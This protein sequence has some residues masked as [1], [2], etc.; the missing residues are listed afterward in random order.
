MFE[1]NLPSAP[2]DGLSVSPAEDEPARPTIP[3]DGGAIQVFRSIAQH[4]ETPLAVMFAGHERW[5]T[6]PPKSIEWEDLCTLFARLDEVCANKCDVADLGSLALETDAAGLG[7]VRKMLRLVASPNLLYRV[8]FRWAGNRIFPHIVATYEELDD[9]RISGTLTIPDGCCDSPN[10]FKVMVGNFRALPQVLGLPSAIVDAEITERHMACLITPPPSLTLLARLARGIRAIFSVKSALEEMG[11]QQQQL[12]R[13]FGE[14]K[15][16]N[17]TAHEHRRRAE[18]E[19]ERAERALIVKSEFIATMSHEVRTPLNGITGGIE[20]LRDAVDPSESEMLEIVETSVARLTQMLEALLDFS[21]LSN[22][23]FKLREETF[24]VRRFFERTLSMFANASE[25]AGLELSCDVAN[26]VPATLV[27]DVTRVGQVLSALLD[28]ALKFTKQGSIAVTV[29]WS[30]TPNPTMWIRV[31]DTGPGIA[32]EHRARIFQ[33]FSQAD[34]SATREAGGTGL[35][36]A[37]CKRLAEALHG[38]LEL[39]SVMGEGST[40]TFSLSAHEPVEDTNTASDAQLENDHAVAPIAEDAQR[41]LVVEDDDVSNRLL[42]RTLE[43]AGYAVDTTADGAE[44]VRAAESTKYAIILMDK[45]MPRMDGLA[46]TR[47]I[48]RIGANRNTPIIAV[49]AHTTM[50]D[51]TACE[52]AGMNDFLAK[53]LTEDRLLEKIL[54]WRGRNIVQQALSPRPLP[55]SDASYAGKTALI[56]EDDPVNRRVLTRMLDRLGFSVDSVEN[57]LRAWQLISERAFD[58][59]LMDCEMPVMD[60]RT[61]TRKIRAL[62]AKRR[63]VPIIAVTAYASA[64]DEA[65]CVEAGM[66]AFLA[67]PVSADALRDALERTMAEPA[68][69]TSRAAASDNAVPAA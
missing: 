20:L 55:R 69:S 36:L 48:R 13:Q 51:Q 56:V 37:T 21:D 43:K 15:K 3:I 35:G 32:A 61:A 18:A 40:F 23:Y 59:V 66:N 42:R 28:N 68:P 11:E 17:E 8:V 24:E 22:G 54:Y 44:A 16:A 60:G 41:V 57:G 39:D 46:A 65:R 31:R 26:D 52:Q 58:V 5:L 38:T 64:D 19:M 1:L 67:K 10:F 29:T 62:D 7:V 14:L 2:D 63:D 49:S 45:A 9:G 30:A 34:S 50:R 12:A 27:T 53:P 25:R 4:T 33:P 6:A 47:S